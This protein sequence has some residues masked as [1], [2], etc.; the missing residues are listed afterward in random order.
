MGVWVFVCIRERDK[1]EE[2]KEM[3]NLQA[4]E[5]SNLEKGSL[6]Q[7]AL[8]ASCP[9][10]ARGIEEDLPARACPPPLPSMCW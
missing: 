9:T 3:E 5:M 2:K 4:T 1:D 7:A 8:V 6:N 10:W